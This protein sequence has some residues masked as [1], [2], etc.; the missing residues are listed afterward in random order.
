MS[1]KFIGNVKLSGHRGYIEVVRPEAVKGGVEYD[2]QENVVD[3]AKAAIGHAERL[4]LMVKAFVPGKEPTKKGAKGE[5]LWSP[6]ALKKLAAEPVVL[7]SRIPVP[8]LAFLEKRV[9]GAAKN[10][11]EGL[12]GLDAPKVKAKPAEPQGL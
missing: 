8:Y 5:N 6:A 10:K 1:R 2:A 12:G 4:G 9:E 7:I 3:L 11:P